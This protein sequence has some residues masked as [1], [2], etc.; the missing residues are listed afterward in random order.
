MDSTTVKQIA[1]QVYDSMA[2]G[3]TDTVAPVVV[4][5]IYGMA[6]IEAGHGILVSSTGMFIVFA[7]LAGIAVLIGLLPHLMALLAKVI[8]ESK[9]T[10]KKTAPKKSTSGDDEAIAVAIAIA[11]HKA[12]GK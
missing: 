6:G 10:A 4:E 3:G 1:E 7:A 11:N 12:A 2:N 5:R 9:P 8:P